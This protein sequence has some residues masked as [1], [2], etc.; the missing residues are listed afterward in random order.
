M[1][2]TSPR[3]DVYPQ[4]PAPPL[5]APVA[6]AVEHV[7]SSPHNGRGLASLIC[8]VAGHTGEWTYPDE[9]CV[10]VRMCNRCG[11]VTSKQEHTWSAFG[12]LTTG[13]CEQQRRCQWCGAVESRVPHRWGPWLYVGSYDARQ[14][15]TCGR[16]GAKEHTRYGGL[17]GW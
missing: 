17:S 16:C 11:E 12:Y 15:H 10:R 7:P 4:T 9:R 6:S 2:T 13:R 1:A 3:P 14:F 5:V 8:R